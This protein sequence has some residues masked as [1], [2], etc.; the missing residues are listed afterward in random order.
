[1]TVRFTWLFV[2]SMFVLGSACGDSAH[3]SA[4]RS[5]TLPVA[6]EDPAPALV[7][8]ALAARRAIAIERLHAYGE[9]RVY[10]VDAEGLP[11][12]VFRDARG[13]RCPMSELIFLSGRGDLVD[14]VVAE[15][16]RLKL[17]DVHDGPL[18]AWMLESGLTQ[19]EIIAVQGLMEYQFPGQLEGGRESLLVNTVNAIVTEKVASA[20]AMLRAGTPVSLAIAATRLTT[21]Q[22]QALVAEHAAH[23]AHAAHAPTQ[24][25]VVTRN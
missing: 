4:H 21:P 15:N 9:A 19:E 20:E 22:R 1:M 12:G 18:M 11:T 17:A 3:R 8:E 6:V 13:V 7:H 10:P 23:A 5:P 25:Q 2:S 14:Q 24:V 16:N